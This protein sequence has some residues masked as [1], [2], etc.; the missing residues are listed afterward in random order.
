MLSQGRNRGGRLA[1][2]ADERRSVNVTIRLTRDE[3]ARIE[4]LASSMTISE[5]LRAAAIANVTVRLGGLNPLME[6]DLR[7][8]ARRYP[9]AAP[10]ILAALRK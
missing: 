7:Q 5:F 9:D 10:A 4:R 8:V 3:Y 6:H 1:K 2:P